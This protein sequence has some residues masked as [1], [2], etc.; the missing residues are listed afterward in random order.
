MLTDDGTTLLWASAQGSA[1]SRLTRAAQY[2]P[3][4]GTHGFC[5]DGAGTPTGPP[6][7]ALPPQAR[8]VPVHRLLGGRQ[9]LQQESSSRGQAFYV[10]F[11][12][13]LN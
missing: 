13:L 11:K 1:S 10:N 5:P 2:Q 9:A 4:P 8:S 6:R 12:N 3:D 7:L